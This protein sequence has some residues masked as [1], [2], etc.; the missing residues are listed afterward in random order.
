MATV[1]KIT[2]KGLPS[3]VDKKKRTSFFLMSRSAFAEYKFYNDLEKTKTNFPD[4]DVID[5]VTQNV[6]LSVD[7][8]TAA[9]QEIME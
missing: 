6:D 1:E 9:L 2:L 3:F 7:E 8:F 4:N 5:F